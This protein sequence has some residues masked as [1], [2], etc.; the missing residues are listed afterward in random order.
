M[1]IHGSKIIR[2]K[3]LIA[4][5]IFLLIV[6]FFND[7]NLLERFT[8]SDK[9]QDL[10][11]QIDFYEQEIDES[12]RKLE[13][14]KTNSENLEK[15]AREEYFMKKDNEDIYIIVEEEK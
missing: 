3:Y 11:S 4:F 10:N 5:I 6:L 13:E 9:K 14:L 8:L 12:N 7:N 1:K 15:F 2:N